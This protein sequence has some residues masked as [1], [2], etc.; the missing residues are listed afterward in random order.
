MLVYPRHSMRLTELVTPLKPLEAMAQGRLLVASDVGGH[1]ELIDDGETGVLFRAGRSRRRWPTRMLRLLA[2]RDRW[3]RCAT[4]ARRFVENERNWAIERRALPRRLRVALRR[5]ARHDACD[6]LTHRA[7]RPAAAAGRRH[8]EPDARS[9][10]ELLAREGVAV[11]VVRSM[12][13]IGRRSSARIRGVRALFRL[14]PYVARAVACVG[15]VDVFH[16]MANSGWSWHL[17]AAPA[18]WIAALRGVP[19]VVNYRG[20]EAARSS[21]ARRASV[22]RTLARADALAVPSRF[23]QRRVRAPRNRGAVVLPNIIDLRALPS[24]TTA[25]RRSGAAHRWSRAI[26]SRSTTSPPRCARSRWCASA[27]RMRA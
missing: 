8:G 7:G 14:V 12:R 10:R 18:I 16:V 17:F 25:P 6:G 19:V 21:R 1:R 3:P 27:C 23:L 13:R 15:R 24:A 2:K 4:Q 5:H 11:D 20:G 9:S 26:S 22:R